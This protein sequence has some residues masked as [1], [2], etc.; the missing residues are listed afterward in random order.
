MKENTLTQES[1][2]LLTSAEKKRYFYSAQYFLDGASKKLL[3]SVQSEQDKILDKFKIIPK[4][5]ENEEQKN[6][7]LFLCGV[8]AAGLWS[9]YYGL[10]KISDKFDYDVLENIQNTIKE[11]RREIHNSL[12]FTA[13]T[14]DIKKHL[15]GG[16]DAT[17]TFLKNMVDYVGLSFDYK[18]SYEKFGNKLTDDFQRNN[19]V[20]GDL[21]KVTLQTVLWFTMHRVLP[22]IIMKFWRVPRPGRLAIDKGIV[23]VLWDDNTGYFHDVGDPYRR[24]LSSVTATNTGINL[25]QD[26]SQYEK[27]FEEIAQFD[28]SWWQSFYYYNGLDQ[29]NI[30]VFDGTVEDFQA[31]NNRISEDLV[32]LKNEVEN[33][34]YNVIQSRRQSVDFRVKY[35][36]NTWHVGGAYKFNIYGMTTTKEMPHTKVKKGYWTEKAGKFK[37][38]NNLLDTADRILHLYAYGNEDP[39]VKDFVKDILNWWSGYGSESRSPATYSHQNGVLYHYTLSSAFDIVGVMPRIAMFEIYAAKASVENATGLLYNY[40]VENEYQKQVM[41]FQNQL[42]EHTQR[43]DNDLD[44]YKRGFITS[45]EYFQRKMTEIE[46]KI[47]YVP[48]EITMETPLDKMFSRLKQVCDMMMPTLIQTSNINPIIVQLK[49]N[50]EAKIA[51][52]FGK[53]GAFFSN[54]GS[55]IMQDNSRLYRELQDTLT[56]IEGKQMGYKVDDEFST[57]PIYND[58]EINGKI[59]G[60][61]SQQTQLFAAAIIVPIVPGSAEIRN[62]TTQEFIKENKD[63]YLIGDIFDYN[64]KKYRV[65]GYEVKTVT[66]TRSAMVNSDRVE[67]HIIG[68]EVVKIGEKKRAQVRTMKEDGSI[69]LDDY[70]VYDFYNNDIEDIFELVGTPPR[71]DTSTVTDFFSERISNTIQTNGM[72]ASSMNLSVISQIVSV[73]S[74]IKTEREKREVLVDK[75]FQLVNKNSGNSAMYLFTT[76]L[77][78]TIHGRRNGST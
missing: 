9:T 20:F 60:N 7:Y 2:K 69:W 64:N 57:E 25:T 59:Y 21:I 68:Y 6:K 10:K 46:E 30:T 61:I 53:N 36:T 13:A 58:T 70:Y 39:N 47:K 75:I 28:E 56:Q 1:Q 52:M 71:R 35:K 15:K 55:P 42:I 76:T 65:V 18:P 14:V 66:H 31:I 12:G 45:Q 67:F 24:R 51:L 4:K 49:Q 27:T 72:S 38:L 26:F 19:G 54:T 34:T 74:M 73:E 78:N 63:K 40:F 37:K 50:Y 44:E 16:L 48:S 29:F 11:K 3:K 23:D 17:K 5:S 62:K 22:D 43:V 32:F 77:I 41:S 33:G 8:L